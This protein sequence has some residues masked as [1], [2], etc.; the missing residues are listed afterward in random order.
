M[1]LIEPPSTPTRKRRN[2]GL[3]TCGGAE[4]M[5]SPR[6]PPRSRQSMSPQHSHIKTRINNSSSILG[7]L[8]TQTFEAPPPYYSP[9]THSDRFIPN[10]SSI[11]F[12]F[13]NST[14]VKF[15]DENS[16]NELGGSQK[17]ISP[18]RDSTTLKHNN[19]LVQTNQH[20][21]TKR[22]IDCFDGTGKSTL[23]GI[24]NSSTVLGTSSN[25]NG[26]ILSSNNISSSS[27]SIVDAP[28]LSVGLTSS[29]DDG[30][31]RLHHA[32][33]EDDKRELSNGGILASPTRNST[34]TIPSGPSRIL[35]APELMDDYYLNLLSWG[36]NNVIAVALQASVYLWHAV[37]GRVDNLFTLQSENYV[38]SVSWCNER[39][40][41]LAVGLSNSTIEIW[42]TLSLRRVR[43]L[44][45]HTAR[46]SAL[47]WHGSSAHCLSS[48][49]RDSVILNHDLRIADAG[50]ITSRYS[51]H[52][53]EVCGLAWSQCGGTLASG[54][55]E[56]KLCIWDSAMGRTA[57]SDGRHSPR[58]VI[59][60]HTAAV[61]ALAWCPWSRHTLASGGGT[62]DRTIRIWNASNGSQLKCVDTGSQVCA[63][64]WS[65]S[66]KELVSSHGF[67]DNQ[68]I[69]WKYPSLSKIKEFRG[70]T[71][72]VLHLAR[73]PD[74]RTVCSAS[75]DESIRFWDLFDG[76]GSNG[77]LGLGSPKGRS[78]GGLYSPKGPFPSFGNDL[79]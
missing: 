29:R 11:D 49:G 39:D 69:L 6:S 30:F 35:D 70:H 51:G 40:N 64:Q 36:R 4:S 19:I 23:I 13:C 62:A 48:G 58:F 43:E 18:Q 33:E 27:S 53:Q 72:R 55:N 14:L 77:G 17:S 78:G 15:A 3:L 7:S 25:G 59:E 50:R 34:R 37:D 5:G 71:S 60:Q 22:L 73:S 41:V 32:E 31:S 79:R 28:F 61:K 56:N 1:D 20:M 67:S 8:D 57:S 10:R 54:G 63:L 16:N 9:S 2:S 26:N 21:Q 42:D 75:A 68:L 44:D 45:G 46:V 24:S 12:D 38:T 66:E 74:G 52:L 76:R 65:T 47:A